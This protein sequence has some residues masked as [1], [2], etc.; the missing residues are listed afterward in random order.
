[1]VAVT[2][3]A[4]SGVAATWEAAASG[5]EATWVVVSGEATWEVAASGAVR[6]E[7]LLAAALLLGGLT[8]E[9]FLG[10]TL[11]A[12][13]LGTLTAERF[14]EALS[15][16][17]DPFNAATSVVALFNEAT[18]V[19]EPFNAATLVAEQWGEET[20]AAAHSAAIPPFNRDPVDR[21]TDV[22]QLVEVSATTRD[23]MSE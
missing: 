14:N 21:S 8:V 11:V 1:M 22:A 9:P 5:A 10:V 2:V 15:V 18:S 6:W 16:M 3:A 17:A 4:A 12:E 7:D 19:A 13:P 20:S 23:R